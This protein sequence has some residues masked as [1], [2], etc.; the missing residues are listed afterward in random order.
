M[1]IRLP[2]FEKEELLAGLLTFRL[3]YFVIPLC[4]AALVLGLRELRLIARPTMT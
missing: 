1:L 3:L 4:L 2:Q